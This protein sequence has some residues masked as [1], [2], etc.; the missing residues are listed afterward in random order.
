MKQ[1]W[2][3]PTSL[4]CGLLLAAVLYLRLSDGGGT[5]RI[6]ILIASV[7]M[8]AGMVWGWSGSWVGAAG[9]SK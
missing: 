6:A 3:I 7:L 4:L 1:V 8:A 5:L 9:R 2:L